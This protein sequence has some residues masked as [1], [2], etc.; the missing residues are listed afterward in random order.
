LINTQ[1]DA[2]LEG[3]N[4]RD[5]VASVLDSVCFNTGPHEWYGAT[6][7]QQAHRF[8]DSAFGTSSVT[9]SLCAYLREIALRET[10]YKIIQEAFYLIFHSSVNLCAL[11]GISL[12]MFILQRDVKTCKRTFHIS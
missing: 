9:A 1:Q 12:N 6:I 3:K 8:R 4:K 2:T 7:V 5:V 10:F 11:F